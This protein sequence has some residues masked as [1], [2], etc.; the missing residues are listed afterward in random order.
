[1]RE[2]LEEFI[3]YL[4][5]EKHYSSY[6]IIGYQ[7]NIED[8]MMHLESKHINSL[9]KVDYKVI[10]DYLNILY[11]RKYS[12]KTISRYISSLRSF[13]RYLL[14]N[15]YIID[16]PMTLISNPKLDKKLPQF[17]SIND[18]EK[19]LEQPSSDTKLGIRDALIIE[20]LYSTG[21]RVSELVNIKLSDINHSLKQ[22]KILGK[23]NK[24]R[25]VLYGNVCE[26]LLDKYISESRSLLAC[27]HDYLIVN[28]RGKNITTRA[29]RDI[30]SKYA[31]SINTHI[32]PHTLRHTFATHML[33]EGA[34]LRTVQ[35][36]LGHENLSTTQVY[37][38]IS[39]E[40]LRNIYLKNHPRAREK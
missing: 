8:F 35:E 29:I 21:I 22:I 13:F 17:L 32:S 27:D 39:N 33:N 14:V 36:L 10:R 31:Y 3:R 34:D 5:I 26:E 30:L 23:G 19:I 28:A 40:R 16:N 25:Y 38:H 9:K 11:E 24:E 6:T 37:T 15:K 2:L 18:M 12:K 4:E 1:M 7:E 20:L